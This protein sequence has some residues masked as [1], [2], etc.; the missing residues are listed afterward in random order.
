MSADTAIKLTKKDFESDQDVRWCPGCG[1][2]AI[3]SAVQK[4]MPE[5]GIAKE[6][7]V[8]V[9]GIGCSSRF[10]YYMNTFGF[11]TIHGRAPTIA[12]GIKIANP[13]LC[14]W[15]ITGD[16]DGLSIGG[17]HFIHVLRRNVDLNILLFNN[18]IYG[19]TKGQYSPTSR[20][21][22]VAKST[23][24]GS[25]DYPIRPLALAMGSGCTWYGRTIDRDVKHMGEMIKRA[26]SHKGTSVLEIMQNCIVFND[27]IYGEMYDPN[28]KADAVLYLE[29]GKPM[30]FGKNN[31]HALVVENN[32]LKQVETATVNADAIVKH[33][34]SNR[35]QAF[36]L[37]ELSKPLPVGTI[38]AETRAC[39]ENDLLALEE[40]IIQEKGPGDLKKLLYAET[41]WEIH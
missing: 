41:T 34:E 28:S 10:P 1:D 24:F 19:L 38:Y 12:T 37:S 3:L 6:K 11:H 36:M 4:A 16:G 23:P 15:V 20:I 22:T 13:E 29:Q 39:Y 31:Q 25:Q 27:G 7:H 2:Y 40:K 14:V 9:A 18:E 30:L 17:N 26:P 5:L 35:V 21:G 32:R 8:F 33:D